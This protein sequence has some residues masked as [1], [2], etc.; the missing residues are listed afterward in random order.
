MAVWCLGIQEFGMSQL[1]SNMDAIIQAIVYAIDNPMGSK[2]IT[3]EALQA[4]QTL[5][6]VTQYLLCTCFGSLRSVV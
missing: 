4:Y 1:E 6:F 2:A 3:Y 5:T